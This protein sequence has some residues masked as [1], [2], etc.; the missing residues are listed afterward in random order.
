[1]TRPLR[2]L[3]A[4]CC[5]ALLALSCGEPECLSDADCAGKPGL[6]GPCAAA[7]CRAER[8]A[9]QPSPVGAACDDGSAC[10]SGDA[11]DGAGTCTGA[12]LSCP[13]G[14]GP[15][16]VGQCDPLSGG[17]AVVPAASGTTCDDDDPCTDSDSCDGA[18]RCVAG[19]ALDCDDA[20]PCTRDDCSAQLGCVHLARGGACDDGD[21]CTRDDRC[22]DD[23]QC[24]G[25][26]DP[27]CGEPF[28]GDAVCAAD[29]SC[30][31][32][33]ADCSP[34]G[35]GACSGSC[36][37][38]AAAPS[39]A[40][41][42]AC[43]PTRDGALNPEPFRLG[44]GVCGKACATDLDCGEARCVFAQGLTSTGLCAMGCTGNEDC[45]AGHSCVALESGGG[46]CL[47][48]T[49]CD[50]AT[51]GPDALCLAA[52]ALED[53]GLAPVPCF[54]RAPS[55]LAGL[56]C[57]RRTTPSLM[58]GT[59]VGQASSC[60]PALQSGCAPTETCRPIGAPVILGHAAVCDPRSGPALAD[61]ACNGDTECAPGL[62]CRDQVCRAFCKPGTEGACGGGFCSDE[63]GFADSP[64]GYC[65][66]GC[67]DGSCD[68]D[69][70]CST[71]PADC[72][73]CLWCGDGTC[74]STGADAEDCDSC[75][76]D[77]N[78]CPTCG[79]KICDLSED[80]A[81]CARDCG[82]PWCG[83]GTCNGSET[84]A[85]CE[86]DCGACPDTCGNGAC[87]P[88]EDC[89]SCASDCGIP[90]MPACAGECDPLAANPGCAANQACLPTTQ[91][92]P[93]W[94]AFDIG[95]G[96]CASGCAT[97]GDCGAGNRCLRLAGVD[98][99]GVC[100]S[101][102]VPGGAGCAGT[103]LALSPGGAVGAC[104]P[105]PSC[106]PGAAGC[107]DPARRACVALAGQAGTGIC[108]EGCFV[109]EPSACGG[110]GCHARTDERWHTGR[111]L[112]GPVCD[113]VGQSGC[114]QDQSCAAL[115]GQALGG[116]S[117][118]CVPAGGGGA[119]GEACQ[120]TT[121]CQDGLVCHQAHCHRWCAPGTT[122]ANGPCADMSALLYLAAGSIGMCP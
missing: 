12:P 91:G 79:D 57:L 70:H 29:E 98:L 89:A 38:T 44:D 14:S 28:C 5:G 3:P 53:G 64:F 92:Q 118:L 26:P 39:C 1:M 117:W 78:A 17:C 18:G 104:L 11:C 59:C 75:P 66:P 51:S 10:T 48:G 112:G 96:V 34:L 106:D 82:C 84:C 73:S 107:A 86:L 22:Q 7:V 52:E 122:C 37:P 87:D 119:A 16:L 42:F 67:G 110:A 109:H 120:A 74:T 13:G 2:L 46:R 55:C 97:D 115:G 56:A 116:L 25:K 62:A 113:A 102:C 105:G 100:G 80:C 90:G 40:P 76:D 69:E 61:D 101:E 54:A 68:G 47:P 9:S 23:V 45:A 33:P 71:C 43:V 8:C 99:T 72:G 41:G 95:N 77:C 30:A 15:C 6:A 81:S 88:G 121:D 85:D 63:S 114:A 65:G 103:C 108:L 20:N 60:D 19:P 32:C 83:D 58:E 36:D 49:G 93:Y 35:M 94:E 50:P 24:A 27:H 21:P 111:C 4:L 31:T